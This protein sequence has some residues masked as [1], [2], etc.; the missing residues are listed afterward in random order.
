M[1]CPSIVTYA[2][3]QWHVHTHLKACERLNGAGYLDVIMLES[4]LLPDAARIGSVLSLEQVDALLD[5]DLNTRVPTYIRDAQMSGHR[6][7]RAFLPGDTAFYVPNSTVFNELEALIDQLEER[8][9]LPLRDAL[10]MTADYWNIAPT[11]R[12]DYLRSLID[13][14]VALP[15]EASALLE[16]IDA[17]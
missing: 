12:L 16:R 11:E 3:C 1:A 10:R 9:S 17:Q 8:L 7:V 13:E 4:D 14:A 15:S 6:F 5:T 2:D